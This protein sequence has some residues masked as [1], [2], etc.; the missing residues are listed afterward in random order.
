MRT[1]RVAEVVLGLALVAAIAAVS[2][3]V[4]QR[5][6]DLLVSIHA[7]AFNRRVADGA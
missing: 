3:A 5:Q 7:D 6:A 1:S 2:F 4:R